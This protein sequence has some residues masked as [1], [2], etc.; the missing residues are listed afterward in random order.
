MVQ[1][2]TTTHLVIAVLMGMLL[3]LDRNEW[4]A[5]LTFGVLVDA[6]HLFALPRYVDDNGWTAI[7]RPTWDDASGLPWK[8]LL[9]YPVGAIIVGPLAVGWRYLVP[10]TFWAVHVAIDQLQNELIEYTNPI[11]A[12][13]FAGACA[14]VLYVGYHRWAA[15]AEDPS[16]GDY[17]R[18][19]VAR[20]SGVF[21]RGPEGTT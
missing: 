10:L 17:L 9:H 6:D 5:A 2:L 8:S 16:F 3:N 4:F 21:R 7:F 15:L 11:E 1:L 12:A 14:G 20:L 18:H 19:A 13:M